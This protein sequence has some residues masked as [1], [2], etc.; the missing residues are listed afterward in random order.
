[1]SFLRG[2]LASRSH[3]A[4]LAGIAGAVVVLRYAARADARATPLAALAPLARTLPL[5]PRG[6]LD[7]AERELAAAAWSYFDRNTDPGTGLA[8]SVEGYPST[9]M[10]DVGS[11]LMALLS[12]EDLGLASHAE[13]RRR[14]E[15]TLESLAALPLCAGTM[16]NKA[17]DTRTL[18]MT[19]YGNHP[20]P[21]GIGWSALDIGRVLVPLAQ[22]VRSDPELTP[23]VERAVGRWNLAALSDGDRLWGAS[24]GIDGALQHHQ[25]GRLGYE[26]YAA[27]A[28]L[29]WGVGAPAALDYRAQLELVQVGGAPVPR[30]TRMPRQHG[31]THNATLSEPWVLIG[32]EQGF[33]AVSLP[34]ARAV[35]AAQERR[36]GE[37]GRL[38]A[39]SED[40]LDRA[41]G[42]AYSAVLNGDEA[43]TAFLPDG[44]P[45]PEDLVFSA[46][47]A[48]GWG[49]LFEGAYPRRLLSAAAELA[50]PRRGVWAGRYDATGEP[51]RVLSLNTNAVVL[52]AL[53]VRERGPFSRRVGFRENEARR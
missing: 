23:L 4:I 33:D 53:S 29:P 13:V 1:M 12:A 7:P 46:K 2:L 6:A 35:L 36:A 41:P 17:Y 22:V 51:N 18:A 52:E 38:T 42:F 11:Q 48:V 50:Q 49:V 47:A 26:Q 9:T 32:L 15:R 3:L 8:G 16:P 37:S 5:R 34:L 27:R 21:Q 45:V 39:V 14:L 30:D 20:A 44:T 25:E 28:L 43:W 10:W 31:G 40:A 24:R 19:D